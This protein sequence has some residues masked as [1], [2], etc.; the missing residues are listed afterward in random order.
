MQTFK[1]ENQLEFYE[2]NEKVKLALKTAFNLNIQSL[3]IQHGFSTESTKRMLTDF[4]QNTYIPVDE[5]K[6]IM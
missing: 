6:Q 5:I 4:L 3:S 2:E 1:P